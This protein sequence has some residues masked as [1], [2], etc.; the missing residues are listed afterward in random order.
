M[1]DASLHGRFGM[2][3]R[4]PLMEE[5]YGRIERLAPTM[6]PI[7]VT[8]ETGSGKECVAR[9][10]HGASAQRK[11]QLV[12]INVASLPD[13][14]VESE[15]FGSSRGAFTGASD[16]Q[17]LLELSHGGTL[18]LDEA[19][20]LPISVQVKLLRT[21][22]SG[23]IRRVGGTTERPFTCRLV[24]TTQIATARL[25]REGRWRRDF[26]FR[27]A[28]ALVRVP[29]LNER[30]SDIPVLAGHFAQ[31]LRVQVAGPLTGLAQRSWP[32][33]VR[34]LRHAIERAAA[35]ACNGH[36][37]AEDIAAAA[38]ADP[39]AVAQELCSINALVDGHVR[40]VLAAC[41]GDTRRAAE[42]LG[43]S[44]SQV[45]RRLRSRLDPDA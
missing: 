16:R 32:G 34:Q 1:T 40:G 19:A 4:H 24:V 12:V 44:R 25:L 41:S 31:L 36:I 3:G 23:T 14:L 7:I 8:G 18:V 5:L 21:L 22:E 43:I 13:G 20:D 39:S 29:S 6:L 27:A 30:P 17:G 2:V 38:T 33:N 35:E 11:G 28:G 15:L 26:Y 10:L 42:I 37:G 9:A 45:Y